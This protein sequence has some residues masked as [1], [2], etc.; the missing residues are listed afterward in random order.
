MRKKV[1]IVPIVLAHV[2]GC[3]NRSL[4]F[5]SLGLIG[6]EFHP[7]FFTQRLGNPSMY[8]Q[9]VTFVVVVFNARDERLLCANPFGEFFLI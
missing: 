8:R 7:Q 4:S 9:R 1:R 6:V 5:F 2:G 3:G